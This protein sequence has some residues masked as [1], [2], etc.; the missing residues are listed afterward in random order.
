MKENCPVTVNEIAAHLDMS[1]GS[2]D[3]I[4]KL[5][6]CIPYVFSKL[7]DKKYLRFPFECPSYYRKKLGTSIKQK[8][9]NGK[10]LNCFIY[11]SGTYRELIFLH[12]S[13]LFVR[14]DEAG[15]VAFC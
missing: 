9:Q 4:K 8:A 5:S 1:H 2:A 13:L 14:Q 7:R 10:I 11:I 12:F 6:Y 15:N 3:Y